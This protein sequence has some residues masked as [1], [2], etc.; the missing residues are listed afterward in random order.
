MIAIVE[1]GCLN[2]VCSVDTYTW[3]LNLIS[4][5]RQSI[6]ICTSSHRYLFTKCAS[7]CCAFYKM[8]KKN[9]VYLMKSFLLFLPDRKMMMGFRM[10]VQHYWR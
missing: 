8:M 10:V 1:S 2:G 7:I 6:C 5:I 4:G 3:K 9:S